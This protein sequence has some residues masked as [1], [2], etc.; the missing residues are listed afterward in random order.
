MRVFLSSN[1]NNASYSGVRYL[2]ICLYPILKGRPWLYE[3][4]N[5]YAEKVQTMT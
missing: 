5:Y 4:F 1:N 2:Y 3:A